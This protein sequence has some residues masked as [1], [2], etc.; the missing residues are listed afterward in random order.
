MIFNSDEKTEDNEDIKV[1]KSE[2]VIRKDFSKN[3][4]CNREDNLIMSSV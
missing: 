2:S 4:F 3:Q 1:N